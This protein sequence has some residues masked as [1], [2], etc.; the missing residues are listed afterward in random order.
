M[1]EQV[2]FSQHS[3][4]IFIVQAFYESKGGVMVE[5]SELLVRR[6]DFP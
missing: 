1:V 3:N 6:I 5:K 2:V 4:S